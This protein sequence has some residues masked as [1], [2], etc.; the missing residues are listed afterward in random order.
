LHERTP[1]L[2]LELGAPG[3]EAVAARGRVRAGW[4][5]LALGASTPRLLPELAPALRVREQAG[6]LVE[7]EGAAR[8]PSPARLERGQGGW[9]LTPRGLAAFLMT[10]AGRPAWA[11]EALLA[12]RLPASGGVLQRWAVAPA[13]GADDLPLVGPLP[14]LPVALACGYG[15]LGEAQAL[16]AVRWAVAAMVSGR[17]PTSE[18]MRAARA[19]ALPRAPQ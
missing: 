1:V 7:M 13:F 2:H 18:P 4:A 8:V 11:L 17:D 14:G 12:A 10:D 19:L 9:R 3:V 6:V 5:F 15:G 16:L